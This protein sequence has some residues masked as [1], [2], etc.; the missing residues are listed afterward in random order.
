MKCGIDMKATFS[1]IKICI[2]FSEISKFADLFHPISL[3]FFSFIIFL[4]PHISKSKAVF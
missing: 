2:T 1:K 4:M 3:T